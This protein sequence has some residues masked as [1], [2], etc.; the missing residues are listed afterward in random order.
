[1]TTPYPKSAP[2]L[3]WPPDDVVLPD[4]PGLTMDDLPSEFED[5]EPLPDDFHALFACLLIET[6]R[7][8]TVPPDLCFSTL[9]MY[10]YFRHQGQVRGLRPDWMGVVGVPTMYQGK[11][12]RASYVIED[13][14]RAPLIVVEAL[15]KRTL[16][17]DLGRGAVPRRGAP[18]KWDVYESVVKIPYYVALDDETEEALLFRHDGERYVAE[19]SAEGRM[20]MPEVGLAVGTW[21]GEYRGRE[22]LWVRFYDGQGALI[23]TDAEREAQERAAKER[24]R[25]AR[26]AALRQAERERKAKERE[27]K[28][29]ERERAAKEVALRQAEQERKAKEAALQELERLRALLQPKETTTD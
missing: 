14:G 26:E 19:R 20:W 28:A 13:E 22:A 9:D 1:M 25:E 11:R 4:R 23:P 12:L 16:K 21:R 15:S 29:K 8:T 6:F 27:R 10:L 7:P 17:T 2:M 24:E 18:R 3:V 5:E